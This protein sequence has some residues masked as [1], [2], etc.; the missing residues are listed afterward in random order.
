MLKIAVTGMG[1]QLAL[2]LEALGTTEVEMS[3]FT[4]DAWD[5][6][7][8]EKTRRILEDQKWDAVINTAAYTA[9]DQAESEMDKAYEVNDNAVATLGKK[10]KEAG[11]YLVHISS[12]YVYDNG[13]MY[14]LREDAPTTPR[15]IYAKTKLGGE[16]RLIDLDCPST[17]FRTS[18]VYSSFGKNFV[19]TMT[20]LLRQKEKLNVVC[21]Q[22]GTPTSAI[23]LASEIIH[24]LRRTDLGTST[25]P[26]VINYAPK[27]WTTWF[28]ITKFIRDLISSECKVIPIPSAEY[29]TPARRPHNSILNCDK[30]DALGLGERLDWKVSLEKTVKELLSTGM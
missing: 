23:D 25:G 12:D 28:G 13:L 29:P 17:I 24:L 10:C 5:I 22:H 9:V 1:G 6:T 26:N 14:P 11:I 8:P 16:Q 19:K 15:G 21:D 18:W 3:F 27:G 30:F 20:H 4:K 2:A 7:D